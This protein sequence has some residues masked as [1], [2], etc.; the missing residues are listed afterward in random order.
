MSDLGNMLE[1]DWRSELLVDPVD[2]AILQ[3]RRWWLNSRNSDKGRYAA[4]T[5]YGK[6]IYLHRVIAGA[7]PGE[8]VDHINGD[9]LDNRRVN[10]RIVLQSV[11]M[12]NLHKT[13]GSSRFQGVSFVRNKPTPWYA[14]I[15]H[16]GTQYGLGHYS[17]EEAA[18][19]AYNVAARHLFGVGAHLNECAPET[20][21]IRVNVETKI[22]RYQSRRKPTDQSK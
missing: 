14:K 8:I 16:L 19:A 20:E 12:Q 18:A 5:R 9:T 17:T 11:N 10:L 15:E 7:G 6:K 3:S 4:S 13:R 1:R 22:A 21:Q 2:T